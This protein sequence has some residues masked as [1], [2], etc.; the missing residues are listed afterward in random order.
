MAPVQRAATAPLIG[1][2]PHL[3]VESVPGEAAYLIA[4][5]RVTAL[6][7]TA[8]SVLAPLLD[9][10]RDLAALRAACAG[11]LP[12][13]QVER[14]VGQLDRAGLLRR[15]VEPG[16][17]AE[18]TYWEL[19]G[20]DGAAAAGALDATAVR[21][22]AVGA[23]TD[24]A[25][26]RA[27]LSGAELSLA[28]EGTPAALTAVVCDDYLNPELALVDEES[29][30]DGVPW[31]PV[32]VNG[33]EIWAGPFLGGRPQ[34]GAPCWTCLADRLWRGRQ[35]EAHVQRLLSRPG[36][37]PRPS[38]SLPAAR[39]AGLQLAA[40]EAAKW[41]AGHRDAHQASLWT[42]DTLTL[43]AVHHPVRRRPQCAG[44]GDPGLVARQVRRPVRLAPRPKRDTSGGGHRSSSPAEVMARYGHHVD[45]L[46]GLVAEIRR[47]PRGPEALNSF[48]A[49][50][51]PVTGT[52]GLGALRA[53]LR[54]TSSGKG[55][56][57]LH[58][59]VSALCEALERH[60]GFHQ[61]DEPAERGSFRSLAADAVH[62]DAVQLFHPRQFEDRRRW[63]ARHSAFQQVCD[64]FDETAE[65]D[66]TP[67]WSLTERRTRLLPTALLYFNAPQAPG[68]AYCW[69]SS[70]GAA[71]G[72][73]LEDAV[74]Q[75]T[76]EL[77]ER[78]A[79]ALWW[80]NRTRQPGV[81]LDRADD[82]WIGE[83]R[84][85]HRGLGREVWAL[86]LTTDLGIPV[87]AA[88]SRR[89]DRAAED[90]VFGFGAHLDPAVALRRA[91]TELNQLMPSVVDSAPDGSGYGS[92]D[93]AAL[94]WFR[95][96]TAEA[97]P[98][99]RPDPA[100]PVVTGRPVATA[101]V[102]EDVGLLQGLLAD[103]GLEL[104]VLDQTRPDVGLPVAKVVVPGL[105]PHWARL[106]PGRLYD[107][108]VRLGRLPAPLPYDRLNP[109]PLFV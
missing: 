19:A 86:D 83:L 82:P 53:G 85:L 2:K 68:R 93:P 6:H 81:D 21:V 107:V 74:L 13:V 80:Y 23:G 32:L 40:L 34:S 33:T 52:P 8:I 79:V 10:T 70:N 99:L 12:G 56:T 41:L 49:G 64:P 87:V 94:R 22:L 76:L 88:L 39:R 26:L 11:L 7:G 109:T 75:G 71:A 84:T 100:A 37:A 31:F 17:C 65:I 47:D 91:L 103:R 90:I 36:P 58:A 30:A 54:H 95:T 24:P 5:R 28:C 63:N 96:A 57:P 16:H 66:W 51:N 3:Q 78:D 104:L 27:A 59:K 60:S 38:T 35:A 69:A 72:A 92:T 55:I 67:V 1:F 29:R 43:T 45:P 105:R 42:L 20:V 97:L 18:R 4:D 98:Y 61:G 108:P 50:H 106:A 46:T 14:L 9:G 25:E 101:D 48:H 77:V 62:P 89:T 102:T 15:A 73:T 44:C